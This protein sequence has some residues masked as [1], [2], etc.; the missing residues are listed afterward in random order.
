MMGMQSKTFLLSATTVLILSVNLSI[1]TPSSNVDYIFTA[2]GQNDISM[3]KKQVKVIDKMPFLKVKVG[4]IDIAYKQL[5]NNTEKPIVLIGGGGTTMDMWNPILLR[6]LSSNHLVIIFD[7][8]GVGNTTLG[9]ENFSIDQFAKDTEGL[10]EALNIQKADILGFSMGSFIAQELTLENPKRVNKLVLYGS[11]CGGKGAV[12]PS[13]QALQALEV[14]AK[15]SSPTQDDRDTFAATMFPPDWFKENPNYEDYVPFPK[16]S[17]TPEIS[18]KQKEAIFNWWTVGICGQLSKITQPTLVIVG[19][20]DVWLP[21]ANSLMIAEKIPGA[22]LVQIK[23]AG[24]G[25]LN[26][27]PDKFSKVVT[28]FLESETSNR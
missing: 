9:M 4:D 23:N 7:N 20:D 5:G 13:P 17:V 3:F 24:H 11:G 8:R 15:K 22:W 21:A 27:Y 19:T 16:E 28:I 10:L 6:E 1:L 14:L 2:Y 12:P 26:Q 25:L 18:Q